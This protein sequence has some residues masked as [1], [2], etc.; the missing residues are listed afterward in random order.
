MCLKPRS[1]GGLGQTV[2]PLSGRTKLKL[3]IPERR[4]PRVRTGGGGGAGGR[5]DNPGKRG[6]HR[7]DSGLRVGRLTF[8]HPEVGNGPRR[9]LFEATIGSLCVGRSDSFFYGVEVQEARG[10]LQVTAG[11]LSPDL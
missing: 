5:A 2:C 7:C 4:E 8:S 6:R 10:D 3:Y 1:R 9:A 11:L